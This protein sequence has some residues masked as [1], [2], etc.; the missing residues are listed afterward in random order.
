MD[1]A[2]R[3]CEMWRTLTKNQHAR[4]RAALKYNKG[5]EK[6]FGRTLAMDLPDLNLRRFDRLEPTLD[7]QDVQAFDTISQFPCRVLFWRRTME[8][9]SRHRN[10]LFDERIGITLDSLM[11]D[12]LHTLHLG[13]ALVW[14]AHALW[15]LILG[16]VFC[17]GE[18][19]PDLH[20]QSVHQLRSCLWPWYRA[21]KLANPHVDIT[22]VQDLTLQMLGGKPSHQTLNTKAAETKGLV[23]F[24]LD[25]LKQHRAR[26]GEC[27]VD[28]LIGAGDALQGYFELL[29]DAPRNVPTLVLQRMYDCV[30][31]HLVLC[32]KA[33]VPLKPK[34]HQVLHMVARTAKHGNPNYYATFTDEGINRLLKKVG[35]SAH[36]AVWEMR[37]FL[38][39]GK[40]EEAFGQ[41]RPLPPA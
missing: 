20:V 8:T 29:E 19:G 13:P 30:K 41:K 1:R 4:V 40:V 38:H 33:H 37:V 34:H 2:C 32:K 17:T 7:L 31:R 25:M 22:E 10:P 14:C 3:E 39:F 9:R 23:P 24:V 12:K 26:L 5:K 6:G 15:Q 36:R 18:V 16:D 21:R 11:V 27:E 35:Q 28:H